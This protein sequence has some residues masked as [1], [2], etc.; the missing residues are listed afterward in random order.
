MATACEASVICNNL[1]Y[2]RSLLR[3][4]AIPRR[5]RRPGQGQPRR[6]QHHRHA[7]GQPIRPWSFANGGTGNV[8]RN[9]IF[10][11]PPQGRGSIL[12]DRDCL[13]GLVSDH[14]AVSDR[15]SADGGETI[16]PLAQSRPH[17]PGPPRSSPPRNNYLSSRPSRTIIFDPAARRLAGQC[18]KCSLARLRRPSPRPWPSCRHRPPDYE[19]R[20]SGFSLFLPI[21]PSS[22]RS[23]HVPS[24]PN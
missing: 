23:P 8:L 13:D 1:I 11:A 6:Q 19:V 2:G 10:C 17:G 14:N 21:N 9:N 20:S 22:T 18:E 24:I 15:L 16:V 12:V 4:F 5:F 7:P 3:H